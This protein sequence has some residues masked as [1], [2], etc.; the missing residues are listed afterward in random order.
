MLKRLL[1]FFLVATVIQADDR[2]SIILIMTDD[3][4]WGQVGYNNHPVLKTPNLDAMAKNGLRFD[5]FYAGAPVCSPTRASVLTGRTNM[6]T[7]VST[8]GYALRLQEKSIATALKKAGYATG[9]FGKWHLNAL[10]GPGIPILGDD[11]WSPGAFGFETWLTVTNFFDI[12]PYMSRNGKF[13]DFKGDSSEVIVRESLKFIAKAAKDKKPFLAVIWDGSPHYPFIAKNEDKKA[14]AHLDPMSQSLHGELVAFDR[15]VGALRKGLRDLNIADNTIIW[16]CSDNGGL[17][18]KPESVCG[19]RGKKGD[20]FEGGIRVPGIIEWP[21]KI[22]P[23]VTQVPA[24]TMDIFPT[25]ADLV[26]LPKDSMLDIIDGISLK[27][28]MFGSDAKR[29]K[30]IPFAM[31]KKGALID[32]DYKLLSVKK[33]KFELYN[34][35]DDHSEAN[36][37]SNSKPEVF[38]KMKKEF[39]TLQASI[40]QSQNGKDYPEG[41]VNPQPKRGFWK[42]DARYKDYIEDFNSRLKR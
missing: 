15:S 6:R 40:E 4:G 7:G 28:L 10:R 21:A 29:T 18:V 11:L 3:Q 41:K 38:T 24:V 1:L 14:F 5:R 32:N 9:H 22:K 36:D 2:P 25:I 42:D 30:A 27:D 23:R 26:D 8:H 20:F 33:G 19:L 31:G 16:F 39:L 37:L 17:E 12:D 35:A 13:E 34:L